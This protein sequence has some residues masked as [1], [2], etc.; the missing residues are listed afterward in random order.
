MNKKN[1]FSIT[2]VCL[3][4]LTTNMAC[5]AQTSSNEQRLVGTWTNLY[6]DGSVVFKADGTVT[7]I[8]VGFIPTHWAAAGERLIFYIPGSQRALRYFHISNDGRTLIISNIIQDFGTP[9]RRN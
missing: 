7:G 6:V 8:D 4:I 5:F 9:F 2:L 3:L 1:I